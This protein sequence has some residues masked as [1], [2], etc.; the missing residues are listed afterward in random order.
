MASGWRRR[1]EIRKEV[2]RKGTI[3]GKGSADHHHQIIKTPELTW[4]K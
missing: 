1:V 2:G 4:R 3:K